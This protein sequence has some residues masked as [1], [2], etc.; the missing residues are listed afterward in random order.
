VEFSTDERDVELDQFVGTWHR[1]DSP[2]SR[3]VL[4]AQSPVAVRAG[5]GAA[6][7]Y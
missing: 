3:R 4:P 1:R 5:A 6:W 2:I 7:Q